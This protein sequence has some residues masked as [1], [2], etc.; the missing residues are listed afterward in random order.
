MCK[1]P[2]EHAF[3]DGKC[4]ENCGDAYEYG[5]LCVYSCPEGF[6]FANVLTVVAKN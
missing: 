6:P 2:C 5:D 3:E 4:V 1:A